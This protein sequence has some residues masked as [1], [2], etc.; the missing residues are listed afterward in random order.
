[1]SARD[2]DRP[3]PVRLTDPDGN[4]VAVVEATDSAQTAA[5]ADY[6]SQ[7]SR[8][9]DR[10]E[11]VDVQRDTT[12]VTGPAW[13]FID[14]YTPFPVPGSQDSG[15]QWPQPP[16][17][18]PD[19]RTALQKIQDFQVTLAAR[20]EILRTEQVR[21]E[22]RWIKVARA[23]AVLFALLDQPIERNADI[24]PPPDR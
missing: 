7:W 18:V 1:M 14:A 22:I 11:F 8:R 13:D 23:F 19:T 20:I 6:E 5:V 16:V 10:A 9:L 3:D 12:S 17:P 24:T 2:D 15:S 4:E 21:D